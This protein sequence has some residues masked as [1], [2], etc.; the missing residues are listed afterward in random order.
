L[1]KEPSTYDGERIVVSIINADEI[2]YL[3]AKE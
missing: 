3:Q 2:G 1:T